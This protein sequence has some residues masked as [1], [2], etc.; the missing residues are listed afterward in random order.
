MTSLGD[1]ADFQSP[2]LKEFENY[3]SLNIHAIAST[4]SAV[5]VTSAKRL[6]TRVCGTY[7]P[8]AKQPIT[9]FVPAV[10]VCAG[11]AAG[12]RRLPST[13]CAFSAQTGI[14]VAGMGNPLGAAALARIAGGGIKAAV[15]TPTG[16]A[17]VAFEASACACGRSRP[18]VE[19]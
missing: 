2:H 8:D 10:L 1:T 18:N 19:A 5:S 9:A 13:T 14:A 6:A 16:V 15:L 11:G 7:S 17:V 12:A 3:D 4:I